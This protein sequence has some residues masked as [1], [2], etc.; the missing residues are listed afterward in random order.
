MRRAFFMTLCSAA[1][2]AL[3]GAGCM[4]D[5]TAPSTAE[6]LQTRTTDTA[7]AR[8]GGFGVLPTWTPAPH[9]GTITL[10]VPIP[11]LPVKV[12]V[13]RPRPGIPN[14]AEFRNLAN[15][16]GVSEGF[17]GNLPNVKDIQLSWND[18]KGYLW[19]YRGSDRLL[20]FINE[21]A[22]TEPVTMSMLPTNDA[23]LH[24]A[25]SFLTERGI[26]LKDYR[27]P[28]MEPDWNQWWINAKATGKCIDRSALTSIRLSASSAPI[29]SARPPALLPSFK[30]QCVS[31]EFPS[32][33]TVTYRELVDSRDV[34]R[35][36]GSSIPGVEIV[37][38]VSRMNVVSGHIIYTA[39]PFRSDYAALSASATAD[40]V[41]KGGIAGVSGTISVTSYDFAFYGLSDPKRSDETYLVPALIAHGSRTKSDGT[42]EPVKIVVPLAAQ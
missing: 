23:I 15:A 8:T 4:P 12:T 19:S 3:A 32:K 20:E 39:E 17:I 11:E 41:K 26:R 18:D 14:D 40:L 34:V 24:V 6:P 36:D 29:L 22:P 27:D 13:V 35:A 10:D 7:V 21:T 38:D 37:V 28:A 1:F 42:V 33:L 25:N 30:T 16:L 31:P 9:T 2:L 5:I